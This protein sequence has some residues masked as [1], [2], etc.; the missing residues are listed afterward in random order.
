MGAS[1]RGCFTAAL[2]IWAAVSCGGDEGDTS[3]PGCGPLNPAA[4]S[5]PSAP[6]CADSCYSAADGRCD[7]G[8]SGA[9]RYICNYG[10]DCTDCG[11]RPASD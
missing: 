8:G 7:D 3:R 11:P 1:I 2:A 4:C 10:T 9:S 5:E 6:L